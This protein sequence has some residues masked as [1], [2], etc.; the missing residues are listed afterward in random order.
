MDTLST[1][2][3]SL[4]ALN[5]DLSL[6]HPLNRKAVFDL[7]LEPTD[8]K[9]FPN[10]FIDTLSNG[11]IVPS[12]STIPNHNDLFPSSHPDLHYMAKATLNLNPSSPHLQPHNTSTNTTHSIDLPAYLSCDPLPITLKPHLDTHPARLA[13]PLP[14]LS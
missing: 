3:S 2:T 10:A 9:E 1:V 12:Y 4:Q 13:A 6:L 11:Q 7:N 5:L 8:E 14:Q